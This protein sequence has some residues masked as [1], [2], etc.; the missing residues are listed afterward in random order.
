MSKKKLLAVNLNEFNLEFLKHGSKKYNCK[1]IKKFLSLK[2][3]KTFSADKEQDKSLDPW[4]QNISINS[5]MKTT[6]HKIYNLGE[7]IPNNLNQ[8]WDFLSRK[9]YRCGVWGPMNTNFKNNKNLKIFLPDPWNYQNK[10]KPFELNSLYSL[11][12]KYAKDYT[13]FSILKNLQ[14]FINF[15]IYLLKT[16]IT[17]EVLKYFPLFLKIFLKN[18]LR[19]YFLFF[20]FDIISLIIF[21]KISKNQNLNFSLIFLNSLAHFQH[22]NWNEV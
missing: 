20:L 19:N 13:D 1:N 11:S 3:I 6:K 10:V 4:V 2:H 22:N 16:N 15:F 21:K 9:N 18:G 7:K 14:Y 5:G 17:Y 8:I 12:R